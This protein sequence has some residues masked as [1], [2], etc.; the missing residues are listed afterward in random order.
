MSYG[1]RIRARVVVLGMLTGFNVSGS[2][3]A[4]RVRIGSSLED[5]GA[6]R[7]IFLPR[8]NVKSI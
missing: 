6:F 5:F 4:L 7:P 3:W 1:F 2:L 8:T